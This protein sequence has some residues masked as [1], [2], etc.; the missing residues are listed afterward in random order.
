MFFA[1]YDNGNTITN[2]KK[3]TISFNLYITTLTDTYTLVPSV[4]SFNTSTG[5]TGDTISCAVYKK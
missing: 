2:I 1:G 5:K 3:D 4:S